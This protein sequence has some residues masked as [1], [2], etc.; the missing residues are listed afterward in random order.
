M[1]LNEIQI[2]LEFFF[3]PCVSM[4]FNPQRCA[5]L[6]ISQNMYTAEETLYSCFPEPPGVPVLP[7]L[8][9]DTLLFCR[10][11]LQEALGKLSPVAY[12]DILEG[13]AEGYVRFHSPEEARVVSDARAE[14]QKEHSWKL[15]ILSGEALLQ[16]W[17]FLKVVE[18]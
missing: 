15:E 3:C 2:V 13:D 18:D 8:H 17:L 11:F 7:Y 4:R 1:S 16:C 5:L 6:H 14:L 12:V 9:S 10:L